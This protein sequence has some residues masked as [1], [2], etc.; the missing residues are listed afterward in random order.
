[1]IYVV[2]END[3]MILNRYEAWASGAYEKAL[4]DIGTSGYRY[5]REEITFMGDMVIWVR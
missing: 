1:M 3:H 5:I 4:E 2:R